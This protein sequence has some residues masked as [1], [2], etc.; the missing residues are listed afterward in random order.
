[1]AR[2]NARGAVMTAFFRRSGHGQVRGNPM[3]A[4]TRRITSF[5]VSTFF[6]RFAITPSTETASSL[7]CQ[8]S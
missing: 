1:M 8:T 3:A 4:T 6:K 2:G 5:A 7:S